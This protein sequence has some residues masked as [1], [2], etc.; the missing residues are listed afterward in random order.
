[1]TG[2]LIDPE[3]RCERCGRLV[4]IE[5]PEPDGLSCGTYVLQV[6]A[7]EGEDVAAQIERLRA[8]LPAS[9]RD[10][11]TSIGF[12]PPDVLLAD[13]PSGFGHARPPAS[14]NV[15]VHGEPGEASDLPPGIVWRSAN[16]APPPDLDVP[17]EPCPDCDGTGWASESNPGTGGGTGRD[18]QIAVECPRGCRVPFT[19][20]VD[21]AANGYDPHQE[22]PSGEAYTD[23]TPRLAPADLDRL[24]GQLPVAVAVQVAVDLREA[25]YDAAI[26]TAG[27]HGVDLRAA[28]G[29]RTSEPPGAR[30]CE[31]DDQGPE[32]GRF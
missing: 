15:V 26:R 7:G 31:A 22:P 2:P 5:C 32:D 19:V 12:V 4:P 9:P 16:D 10:G 29:F 28:L 14:I 13:R 20:T 11:E 25:R 24:V 1:M 8:M 18:E 3:G 6:T 21:G 27:Q 30:G 17:P 23:P